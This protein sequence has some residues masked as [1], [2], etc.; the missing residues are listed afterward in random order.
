MRALLSMPIRW[1]QG[2]ENEKVPSAS[3][4]LITLDPFH[5]N[6]SKQTAIL[7]V[8]NGIWWYLLYVPFFED[9]SVI[10]LVMYYSEAS[11][12]RKPLYTGNPSIPETHLYRKPIYTGNPSIPETHLYRKPLYTGNPSKL[13]MD[14][15]SQIFVFLYKL[16]PNNHLNR[17]YCMGPWGGS[18]LEWFRCTYL[19]YCVN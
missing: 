5:W 4:L 18:S 1:N 6:P 8:D 13:N 17:T 19:S 3:L 2:V 12:Y 11:L 7:H 16:P 10:W 14:S 9:I 15:W